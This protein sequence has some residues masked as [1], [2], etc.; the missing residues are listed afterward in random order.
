MAL[1][2]AMSSAIGLLL[3]TKCRGATIRSK[4]EK[5]TMSTRFP[6]YPRKRTH[7]GHRAMSV[8]C[9]ERTSEDCRRMSAEC[10]KRAHSV[11]SYE[12]ANG[13]GLTDGEENEAS[14]SPRP[15]GRRRDH[16]QRQRKDRVYE[17][18]QGADE[19]GRAPAA[20]NEARRHG[21]NHHHGDGARPELQ[22]HRRRS[23][24]IAEQHQRGCDEQRDL[25]GAAERDAD[26][27]VEAV[28]ASRRKGHGK[29]GGG[30]DQ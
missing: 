11:T 15:L 26:A 30:A 23:D 19:P 20:R 16:I 3:M 5:L 8:S 7:V 12:R 4:P 13:T 24:D 6:L 21:R 27:H 25:G 29:L 1:R 9:Q 14:A 18:E 22:A 28:L 17:D 10:Q 2:T